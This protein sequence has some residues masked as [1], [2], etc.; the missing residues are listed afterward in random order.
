[1]TCG[2]TATTAERRNVRRRENRPVMRRLEDVRAQP[3][4]KRAQ[5]MWRLQHLRAQPRKKQVRAMRRSGHLRAQPKNNHSQAMR[6]VDH[7]RAHPHK[8]RVHAMRQ[9]KHLRAQPPKKRLQAMCRPGKMSK[10]ELESVSRQNLRQQELCYSA[11]VIQHPPL[12][13]SSPPPPIPRT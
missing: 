7:L 3:H 5:A 6:G 2:D 13:H 10:R 9:L 1:M 12:S 8:K 11:S 4:K